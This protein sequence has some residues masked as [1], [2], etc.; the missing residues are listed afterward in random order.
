MVEILMSQ[1]YAIG[2]D[3][4]GTQIRAAVVASHGEI[5]DRVALP[6][7]ATQGPA[8]VLAQILKATQQLSQRTNDMPIGVASPGPLDTKR[9]VTLGLPTISGFDHFPF[10]D[11]LRETFGRTVLLT[12]DGMAA[13]VG[14]WKFGAAQGFDDF[15]YVTVSTGIGGGVI[16]GGKIL[17][18]RKGMA[19]HVGHILIE[20]DGELCNCG[21]KGC[22]EAY[23][24]GP[25][26]EKRTRLLVKTKSQSVLT[27]A[28][29]A[30]D[31]FA[32]AAAGD[33]FANEMVDHEAWL[34]GSGIV[35]LLH[36]YDPALVVMGGGVSQNFDRLKA[37]ITHAI[38]T[39][40][41]EAF[42][43]VP[44]R[45]ARNLGDSGLLGA[46]AMAFEN[47]L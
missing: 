14:E 4:G 23:A 12:H 28:S 32:A 44:L 21:R 3:I 47:V 13:A 7:P 19:A 34:L 38:N 40:A 31:I 22:W 37:G 15:V 8:A 35:S 18:G 42:R 10:G 43:D 33:A 1:K 46:A 16:A 36:A 41:M 11:R 27:E 2:V 39:T 24:S 9:G 45:R 26:F 29:T 6:T 20:M 5:I 25:A 17:E 30:K